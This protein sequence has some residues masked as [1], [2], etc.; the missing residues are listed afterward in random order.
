MQP[1]RDTLHAFAQLFRARTVAGALHA[2]PRCLHALPLL[3]EA[4]RTLLRVD[5]D[6]ALYLHRLGRPARVPFG[7]VAREPGVALDRAGEV[8]RGMGPDR[9]QRL[10]RP[11]QRALLVRQHWQPLRPHPIHVGR[12]AAIALDRA[13][14]RGRQ[15]LPR[16][17]SGQAGRAAL[18]QRRFLGRRLRPEPREHAARLVADLLRHLAR[19]FR[20]PDLAP[21]GEGAGLV[22]LWPCIVAGH[23]LAPIAR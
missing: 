23:V 5:T 10:A 7:R 18:R 3:H 9:V 11:P 17:R 2:G 6:L 21:I 16:L 15:R 13:G 4:P 1:A 14:L 8:A 19:E 12:C 22:L 20:E